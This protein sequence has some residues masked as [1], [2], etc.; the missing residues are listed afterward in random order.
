MTLVILL[1]SSGNP[2]VLRFSKGLIDVEGLICQGR[3]SERLVHGYIEISIFLIIALPSNGL[4]LVHLGIMA[5]LD[6][7]L[8]SWIDYS[9][10]NWMGFMDYYG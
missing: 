7:S 3:K 5:V 4:K 8:G 1:V 10:D 6:Y 2:R 9:I